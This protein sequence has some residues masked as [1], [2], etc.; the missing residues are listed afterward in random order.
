MTFALN[1][2]I[3]ATGVPSFIHVDDA[4]TADPAL[5]ELGLTLFAAHMI[6]FWFSQD[7][8]ITPP[9]CMAAF[10]AA[11]IAG[12]PP[13]R[14]GWECVKL[15][16]ALYLTP[17]IFAYG[18]LLDESIFEVAFDFAAMFCA[19]ALLPIMFE[20]YAKRSLTVV[21]RCVF[22]VAGIILF[23]AAL[24]PA[25]QGWPWLVSGVALG[26]TVLIWARRAPPLAVP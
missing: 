3:R 16:K 19:F 8:N 17:F 23:I 1:E 25:A 15:A 4:N 6:I 12:A 2:P 20:G 13:M 24:G 26:G 11:R 21:E 5:S 10:V 14:T 18:S 7:S 22:A 9:I